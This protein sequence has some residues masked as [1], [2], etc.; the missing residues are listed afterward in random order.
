M[1]VV[2]GESRFAEHP[3]TMLMWVTKHSYE[4]ADDFRREGG[5]IVVHGFRGCSR[6]CSL[7]ITLL[8][9]RVCLGTRNALR[10]FV[11]QTSLDT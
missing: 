4:V 7:G 2:M 5:H 1:V 8:T 9:Q 3:R 11:S 10:A 6:G